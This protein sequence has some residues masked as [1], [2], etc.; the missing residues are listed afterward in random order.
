MFSLLLVINIMK[1]TTIDISKL[2][3]LQCLLKDKIKGHLNIYKLND[4]IIALRQK[5]ITDINRLVKLHKT[6]EKM[7]YI[8]S[9]YKMHHGYK[10]NYH[11]GIRAENLVKKIY[12]ANGWKVQQSA[13]SRGAAD[14]MCVNKNTAHYVQCKSST[15]SYNPQISKL[16]LKNLNDVARKKNAIPVVAKINKSKKLF[17][18]YLR[19]GTD[20]KLKRFKNKKNQ[21]KKS[22]YNMKT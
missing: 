9:L 20:V 5:H 7:N 10:S 8:H 3:K 17:I 18:K 2:N 11:T 1:F 21:I 19:N 22:G 6:F 16:E 12:E 13:G 4:L 14:L 15:T